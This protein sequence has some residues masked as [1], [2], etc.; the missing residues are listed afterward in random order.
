MDQIKN[1]EKSFEKIYTQMQRSIDNLRN[2]MSNLRNE[3][4]K[5]LEKIETELNDL[6][7]RVERVEERVRMIEERVRRV[8]DEVMFLRVSRLARVE[9]EE[10][11]HQERREY[12]D[13]D[14]I[15]GPDPTGFN[16]FGKV[17]SE[18]I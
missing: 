2:E 18:R 15:Y 7:I 10:T 9:A 12:I 5:K 6:K 3:M 13:L 16:A 8:E 4:S 1:F 11:I 17:L 14:P